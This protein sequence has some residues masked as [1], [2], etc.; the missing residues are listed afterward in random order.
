MESFK[1]KPELELQEQVQQTEETLNHGHEDLTSLLP[2]GEAVF[3]MSEEELSKKYKRRYLT[4]VELLR[5]VRRGEPVDEGDFEKEYQII[6]ALNTLKEY[7]QTHKEGGTEKFTLRERQI[8]TLQK[9]SD[10]LE[11]GGTK[12]HIVM[13]TGCGKTVIFLALVEAMGLKTFICEP[14]QIIQDQIITE[15]QEKTEM[16]DV[17]KRNTQKRDIS[18]RVVVTTYQSLLNDVKNARL[19]ENEVDL[20]IRDEAHKSLGENTSASLDLVGGIQIGFT[21]TEDYE[22]KSVGDQLP[23]CIDKLDPIEAIRL[24][25]ISGYKNWVVGTDISLQ[26]IKL[27]GSKEDDALLEKAVDVT[28]RNMVAVD[29]Y[30]NAFR[31][32]N[33]QGVCF[34]S[35]I[36][37][38]ENV[39]GL[40]NSEGITARHIDGD[41]SINERKE[42]FAAYKRGEI[43]ILTCSDVLIEG[44][45][46]KQVDVIFNLAPS[47]SKVRVMQRGGR[48]LRQDE[49]RD[50]PKVAHIFDFEDK[51]SKAIPYGYYLETD[52]TSTLA[53]EDEQ[54]FP[55][56]EEKARKDYESIREQIMNISKGL[57]TA[58][59]GTANVVYDKDLY[60]EYLGRVDERFEKRGITVT[61]EELKKACEVN[62]IA[63]GLQYLDFVK[64]IENKEKTIGWPIALDS[65]LRRYGIKTGT[66]FDN[67]IRRITI[68]VESLQT[69]CEE[70][71]ITSVGQYEDF[72]VNPENKDKTKEW[73]VSLKHFLKRKDVTISDFFGKEKRKL[74]DLVTFEKLKEECQRHGINSFSSYKEFINNP[75][76]EEVV[77]DWP[78]DLN[79]FT[80]KNKGSI[81][82]LFDKDAPIERRGAIGVDIETLKELCLEHSISSSRQYKRFIKD[83]L[84]KNLVENWPYSLQFFLERNNTRLADFFGRNYRKNKNE[85]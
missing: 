9:I 44:F 60:N 31:E 37:H 78:R 14:T 64:K 56:K 34:C 55:E 42:I 72:L 21:A 25:M 27:D 53:I 45:D 49:D 4:Y 28:K 47:Q 63:N 65:F 5:K 11:A 30:R 52:D 82:T 38:S 36:T 83:P 32:N 13:P 16:E 51:D 39:A 81:A 15:I 40:F 67:E 6:K 2:D 69:L 19:G 3:S 24:K 18:K 71:N 59:E 54:R 48:A 73:P 57:Q 46:E 33:S 77:K 74:V 22:Y 70:Y 10:W 61:V 23:D 20:F 29:I 80:K 43:S 1:F 66:F 79:K 84:N 7:I 12:G 8:E 68:T 35:G 17:A 50:A 85:Q 75:P 41:T 26:G 76:N 58:L 62:G